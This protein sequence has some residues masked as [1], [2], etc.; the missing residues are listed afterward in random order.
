M[1]RTCTCLLAV[2]VAASFAAS[3]EFTDF[4]DD[5]DRPDYTVIAPGA[6]WDYENVG[7]E[8]I[9]WTT[10]PRPNA[11]D[12]YIVSNQQ[13]HMFVGPTDTNPAVYNKV[14]ASIWPVVNGTRG[15]ITFTSGV[16]EA[17]FDLTEVCANQGHAWALNQEIKLVLPAGPITVDPDSQTNSFMVKCSIRPNGLDG[18]TRCSN[19]LFTAVFNSHTSRVNLTEYQVDGYPITTTPVRIMLD[20]LGPAEMYVGGV[21]RMQTN[22]QQFMDLASM[23]KIYPYI[24]HGKFQGRASNQTVPTLGYAAIDNFNVNWTPEPCGGLAA[25]ALAIVAVVRTR[26]GT[27]HT[28]HVALGDSRLSH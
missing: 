11:Q 4:S 24:W 28:R 27:S 21:L 22:A 10:K 15:Y 8:D 17:G 14:M 23:D 9:S 5:F 20:R 19:V 16:V 1:K 25:L 7:V 2:A 13:L 3:S 12:Q 18:E 6:D 26:G